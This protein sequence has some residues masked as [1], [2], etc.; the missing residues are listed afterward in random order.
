LALAAVA[1]PSPDQ[2]DTVLLAGANDLWKCNVMAGCAWR[3]TTNVAQPICAAR[4]G[5]F[6]HALAWNENNPL[7]IF[8][9]NDSGLWR[10]QDAIGETGSACAATDASH[11]QNLNGSLGSL[12]EVASIS[13][14]IA[15]PYTMM[16]GLGTN[17]T[18]GVQSGT[19]PTAEWPQILGSDGGPVAIDPKTTSNWYA[20]NEAGVSVY[21][22]TPP[23]G[24][25]PGAFTPVLTYSTDAL[26]TPEV[27]ED[28]L[29]MTA[30]AP[31]LVDPV[32]PTQLLIGTCRV[33]RGPANGI[34]WSAGNA[35]SPIFD[36]QAASGPCAG[37][38][39]IRS[40]TAA[41]LPGG[42]EVVYV[43]MYGS[44]NG[45][46][47]L[48]G[49]VWS[50]TFNPTSGIT[51]AWTDLTLNPVSN[52]SLAM[53]AYG[54][55]ISSIFIDST[56]DTSGQTVYVTVE[57]VA[58]T[59]EKPQ[60]AY[61]STD[62]GAHW[63]N[64]TANLPWAPA[65]SVVVDPQNANTVYMAT[66]AGVYFTTQVGSCASLPPICWSAFGTGLPASPVVEL[67]AAPLTASSPVLVAAT[68]GR[69]IWQTPLWT[70]ETG[71]TT[72]IANPAPLVFTTPVR[73]NSSITLTVTLENTGSL[74]LTPTSIATTGEFTETDNCQNQTVAVGGNC[75]ITVTFAPTEAG[76]LP[77]LGQ[78][79]IYANV[80]GGQLTVELSGT[81]SPAGTVTLTPATLSFG[82]A[83]GQT[84]SNPVV[85]VGT[86]SA[87]QQVEAGNSGGVSVSIANIAITAPFVLA[88]N[89][90]GTVTLAPNADCQV[91]VA[92]APTQRG[93]AAGTLTFTDQAGTQTVQL[94]GW[95]SAPPTDTLG[96]TSLTF[97]GTIVGLLSA[98][99][100]VSL[101]NTGDLPLT[102]IVITVS[103]PF[104]ESDNCNGQLAASSSC[105]ISVQFA[106]TAAGAQTGTLTVKDALQ[107]QTVALSGMGL[108]P[109]AL[110]VNPSSLNFGPQQVGVASQP[111]TLT[112]T[113][114][115]GAPMANVGF[116]I[117]GPAASSFSTGAATCG[118][119]LI[120]GSSCTVQVIFTPTAGGGSAATLTVSSSTLGVAGVAVPLNGNGTTTTALTASPLQLTFPAVLTGQSSTAQTVTV[121]NTGSFAATSLA[122]TV[123]APFSL[124]QDNCTGQNLAAGANCTVGVISAPTAGGAATGTLTIS[125]ASVLTPAT[126][127]LS[128]TGQLP[129]DFTVTGT[130]TQTVS[131]GQTAS[132]PLTINPQNVSQGTTT[133]QFQCTS[134]A[135]NSICTFN[136]G[137]V[138][139]VS[140]GAT[141]SVSVQV[142]TGQS[143]SSSLSTGPAVWRALPLLCGLLMLP[144]AHRRRGKFLLLAVLLAI[145][146]GGVSSCSGSGGG[147][148][149]SGGQGGSGLTPA[150]TY[151]ISVTVTA[152]GV[153]KP[154][155]LTLIVD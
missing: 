99:Q 123:S 104:T 56:H 75:T 46:T 44:A 57:G 26:N 39:L 151:T 1:V 27:V 137:S 94:S 98:A 86:T 132:F 145:A 3:N 143:S 105:A 110:S 31:F 38:A 134:P 111:Q 64:L 9:G 14:V 34:G 121:T 82:Q 37:D 20:N 92:F 112:V 7:E 5:E 61:R 21:L 71:L 30:P 22:V 126:V 97:P 18:A 106:P 73:A 122:L 77:L 48:P 53:N 117:A 90:C 128:G 43:G 103:G 42:G 113:N 89:S 41:A 15:T 23:T 49:H 131:A 130:S 91:M 96:S 138:I 109:P 63:V 107:T 33:W 129:F 81:G 153:Q 114:T 4:V 17:G 16:A 55:D 28:G 142:S 100:S 133:F 62:G 108:L 88:S 146:A 149:G 119:T 124:T 35:I 10:S 40:M 154:V 118:A 74:A 70:A 141:G 59:M 72:A 54:M 115:G 32:D 50:A 84:T 24:A 2:Q 25:T 67:S 8:V 80:Y 125:S 101:A 79:T 152:N 150:G 83:P 11:F 60:M 13:Q 58:S 6:Q 78:M 45:D 140:V 12:A 69:G 51:P 65:N 144:L 36:D 135:T 102:G 29:T 95:G 139:Q 148:G 136:P 116:Q 85:P 127:A 155:S 147:S 68:Y 120:S 47:R 76:P 19:A 87:S 52:N 66:D 93:A